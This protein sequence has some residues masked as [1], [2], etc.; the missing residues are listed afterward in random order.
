MLIGDFLKRKKHTGELSTLRHFIDWQE[1]IEEHAYLQFYVYI[2]RLKELLSSLA[3]HV[4]IFIRKQ[5]EASDCLLKFSES[6]PELGMINRM[7][8]MST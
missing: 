8:P 6:L 7:G 2:N 4:E 3:E 1:I 5:R